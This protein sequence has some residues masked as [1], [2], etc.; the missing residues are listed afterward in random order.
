[1]GNNP[2][3]LVVPY[4]AQGHVIPLWELSK[5]LVQQGFNITFVNTRHI[6]EKV[7]NAMSLVDDDGIMSGDQIRVALIED[8][9]SLEDRVRPG[10][11]SESVLRVMPGKVEELIENINNNNNNKNNNNNNNNNGSSTKQAD[12][13][14]SCVVCDQSLGWA[15]DIAERKGIKRAAF[16]PAAAALLVQ[17]FSIPKLIDQGIINPDGTL[18]IKKGIIKLSSETPAMNSANFVWTCLGNKDMQK[19]VFELMVKNNTSV[20]KTDW[21]ICNSTYDLEPSAFNMAPQI[22]PIGPLLATNNGRVRSHLKASTA[23]LKWLDQQRPQSAIYIAFGSFTIFNPT[24]LRELALGLE[25]SNRPFLWVVRT[26]KSDESSNANGG[27]F[28]EG[29]LERVANRGLIVNWAPQQKVLSHGSVACFISHCGWNSTVEGVSYGV[30]FL[31]WPY[32]A[33]QFINQSYI[34]DVWRTGLGFDRDES[35]VI[36]RDEIRT[37][38]EKVIND[39]KMKERALRY[40][41]MAAKCVE[42]GGSSNKN[43]KD[44]IEWMKS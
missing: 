8:G 39:E 18:G 16:C 15:L 11:L 36:P 20:K 19:N 44:F 14:I 7:Q 32:F 43:F 6:H 23:C 37:K 25:L 41:E 5:R 12:R 24:Q 34:C 26:D 10:K 33:D 1:M 42:E 4:P 22:R 40:K 35:G 31:C 28:P 38:V 2:H 17:A 21:L 3:V 27:W 9:L 13:K 29:F 30:P